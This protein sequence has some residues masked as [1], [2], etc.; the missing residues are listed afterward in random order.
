MRGE[1]EGR[2][3]EERERRGIRSIRESAGALDSSELEEE[4][5]PNEAAREDEEEV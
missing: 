3:R 5:D 2:G 1:E 4:E